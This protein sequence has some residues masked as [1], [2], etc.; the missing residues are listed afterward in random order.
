MP[1]SSRLHQRSGPEQPVAETNWRTSL[2]LQVE[3]AI[4]LVYRI[5]SISL[6]VFRWEY[7]KH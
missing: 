2:H 1:K 6:E 4:I 3:K 7:A 5:D